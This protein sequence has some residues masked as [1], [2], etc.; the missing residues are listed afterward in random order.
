M[1]KGFFEKGSALED[2]VALFGLLTIIIFF[3]LP[4]DYPSLVEDSSSNTRSSEQ[5]GSYTV[6]GTVSSERET[7]SHSRSISLG[8]GNASS[9]YNPYEEY[10]T[11]TN[12]GRDAVNITG[13]KLANN[14]DARV[15]NSGQRFPRDEAFI[16]QAYQI[17]AVPGAPAQQN[18]VLE[19]GETAIVTTG[20]VG[21]QSPYF[22]PSF[23]ENMCTGYLDTM[24]EY[25]FKP[26]LS[27][28]C[29][30]PANE[31]GLETLTPECRDFVKK[32]PSCQVPSF[33]QRDREGEPCST[34]VNGEQVS[35][36]C[37]AFIQARFNYGSCAVVH[38]TDPD[39]Y[40]KTW[41]V[42]L[43]KGWEMWA[44]DYEVIRLYD[45]QGNL[46]DSISY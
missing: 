38:G 15:Y 45:R 34:C 29:P 16:P 10:V 39:F 42:Y 1:D 9:A 18:V 2:Y 24:D 4:G 44:E 19:R 7:S 36:S 23:R 43:R 37:K 17:V 46:V 5:G 14:K 22:I 8:K 35:S 12:R 21:S 41:R 27:R 30:R 40:G 28:S 11:I 26:S 20:A 31:P 6:G 3:I 32:L 25:T 13:W 33:T